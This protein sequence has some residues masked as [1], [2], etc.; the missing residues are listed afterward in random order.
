MK[1]K[2]ARVTFYCK[3]SAIIFASVESIAQWN[4]I[5][6][7]RDYHC[8]CTTHYLILDLCVFFSLIDK[9]N[10]MAFFSM[11]FCFII[12]KQQTVFLISFNLLALK[13]S[14]FNY[15]KWAA[16]KAEHFANSNFA[17]H[18]MRWLILHQSLT[19][20]FTHLPNKGITFNPLSVHFQRYRS[21][22]ENEKQAPC[23]RIKVSAYIYMPF[24]QDVYDSHPFLSIVYVVPTLSM[25]MKKAERKLLPMAFFMQ[26]FLHKKNS[27]RFFPI[28]ILIALHH[29][30]ART[31]HPSAHKL[32]FRVLLFAV[33]V[34]LQY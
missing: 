28:F 13:C 8:A 10:F 3:V 27:R 14:P 20:F 23:H 24:L 32:L 2:R 26:N 7:T 11:L 18:F 30:H 33:K 22:D 6:S 21:F 15:S 17:M 12:S 31:L 5:D 9:N 1:N 29:H 4:H 25:W 34:Y 16:A 19:L